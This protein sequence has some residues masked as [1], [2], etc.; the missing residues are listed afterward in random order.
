MVIKYNNLNTIAGDVT[1]KLAYMEEI[2]KHRHKLPLYDLDPRTENAWIA[3][4]ATLG[5]I[6]SVFITLIYSW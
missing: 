5:N 1:P 4:N 6:F 3:P 2:S